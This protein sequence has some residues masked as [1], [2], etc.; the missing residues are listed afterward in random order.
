L[1]WGVDRVGSYVKSTFIEYQIMHSLLV[2][3]CSMRFGIRLK[4]HLE[5]FSLL[6][7]LKLTAGGIPRQLS[8]FK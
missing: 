2:W 4:F 7:A 5:L 6:T 1:V 8:I 3:L